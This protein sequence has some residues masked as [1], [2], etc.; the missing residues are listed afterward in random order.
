MTNARSKPVLPTMHFS[1]ED[2]AQAAAHALGD[3][4]FTVKGDGVVWP[5]GHFRY[6]VDRVE[7]STIVC[8]VVSK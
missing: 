2:A 6:K 4:E 3:E 7:G 1:N 5:F 8:K